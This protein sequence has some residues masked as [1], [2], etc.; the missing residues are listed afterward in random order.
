MQSLPVAYR[1]AASVPPDHSLLGFYP[2]QLFRI[3][4]LELPQKAGL[5]LVRGGNHVACEGQTHTVKGHER[6][7]CL[8]GFIALHVHNANDKPASFNLTLYGRAVESASFEGELHI[9]SFVNEG[10]DPQ[11]AME[12]GD[13]Y[14][15]SH[16]PPDSYDDFVRRAPDSVLESLP[17]SM[18]EGLL[19]R[20][21]E[22]LASDPPAPEHDPVAAA[23]VAE[24]TDD[25]Q[26][27]AE[28][29]PVEA[30]DAPAAEVA[31][32]QDDVPDGSWDEEHWDT[33]EAPAGG[34]DGV[35]APVEDWKNVSGVPVFPTPAETA[36]S[37][38]S[39]EQKG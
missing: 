36:P 33:G 31:Q 11:T 2:P 9:G 22:L 20:R 6:T 12:D 18:R 37:D 7:L 1:L 29:A 13:P 38:G 5:S 24:A 39:G 16:M 21:A 8:G 34:I 30:A 14:G 23:A 35:I 19:A 10:A 32:E 25:N 28:A 4:S 27:V 3:D 26:V 15:I 17:E